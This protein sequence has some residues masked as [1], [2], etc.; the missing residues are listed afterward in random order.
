MPYRAPLGGPRGGL[1]PGGPGWGRPFC[2]P[3]H[4]AGA[5]APLRRGGRGQHLLDMLPA[6]RVAR[7]SALAARHPTTHLLPPAVRAWPAPP[8]D[9][10][11][12]WASCP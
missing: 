9:P 4:P 11:A 7:Q 10:G 3:D 12:G 2:G 5:A 8:A 1:P 6:A